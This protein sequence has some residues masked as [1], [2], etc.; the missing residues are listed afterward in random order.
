MA[1]EECLQFD[2]KAFLKVVAQVLDDVRLGGGGEAGDRCL[3]GKL[4]PDEARDVQIVRAKVVAP[5]GETVGFVEDPGRDL[6]NTDGFNKGF[7]SELLG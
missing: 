7:A 3:S 6:P 1:A 5:L 2:L 4:F